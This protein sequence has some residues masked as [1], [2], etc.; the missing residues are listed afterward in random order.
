MW[1]KSKSIMRKSMSE[2]SQSSNRGGVRPGAGRPEGSVG[3][4]RA[5]V[6]RRREL[7]EIY[8]NLLGGADKLS[9]GQK[10]DIRRVAE[11]AALA[12]DCRKLALQQDGPGAPGAI[13][14]L[15]KLEGTLARAMKRLNLPGPNS[16]APTLS[17]YWAEHEAEHEHEKP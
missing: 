14:V 17:Q 4:R 7:V 15:I 11:L 13:S 6:R 9:E 3:P 1:W 10:V 5:R 2:P 16:A 12:E 8:S